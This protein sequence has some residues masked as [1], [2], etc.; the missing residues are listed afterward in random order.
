MNRSLTELNV[1]NVSCA[2]PWESVRTLSSRESINTQYAIPAAAH[3]PQPLHS[4]TGLRCNAC[5]RYQIAVG[6]AT[7]LARCLHHP[8]S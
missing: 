3:A 2:C 7:D 1:F 6:V 8:A 5:L 4:V